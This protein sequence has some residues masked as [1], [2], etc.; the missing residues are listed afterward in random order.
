MKLNPIERFAMNNPIR[1][2]IQRHLEMRRLLRLGGKVPGGTALEIGC[3]QGAGFRMIARLFGAASID[4][5]DLDPV[6]IARAKARANRLSVPVNVWLG[7]AGQIAVPDNAYDAVFGFGVLHHMI[8]W[9][10]AIREV[11]R[12]LKPGGVYYAEEVPRSLITHPLVRLLVEHPQ[13]DRFDEDQF[14]TALVRSGFVSVSS[15]RF[16]C[17]FLW[18]TG[19][20]PL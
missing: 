18:F 2:W 16:S 13:E 9:H 20:K 12:V 17:V 6:M 14:R 3:G 4:A 8:D 10:R 1:E 15:D 11:Y 19:K 7:S 5:F